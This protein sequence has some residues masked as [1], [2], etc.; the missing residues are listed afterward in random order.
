MS[1]IYTTRYNRIVIITT[2][3][4]HEFKILVSWKGSKK[5]LALWVRESVV[6]CSLSVPS[7]KPLQPGMPTG[8]AL[9][10]SLWD[11]SGETQNRGKK[12]RMGRVD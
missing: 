2:R 11:R 3:K 5:M 1:S 7:T 8:E 9:I 4:K 12:S 10:R 6:N